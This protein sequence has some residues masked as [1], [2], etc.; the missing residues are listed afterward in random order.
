MMRTLIRLC[1]I[2]LWALG[3]GLAPALAAVHLM[4]IEEVYPGTPDDPDAQYVML[5]MTAAGQR[6]TLN[7]YVRVEDSDGNLLGR[8]GTFNLHVPIGG[9][10][11]SYPTCPAVLIGTQAAENRLGFSFDQIVDGQMNGGAP[12]VPLPLAAGR[13]CFV[14]T[15]GT[16]TYDCVAWEN[17]DCTRSGNCTAPNNQRTGNV[18]GNG[19]DLNFD[20]PTPA[21]ILGLAQDRTQF[22]CPNKQNSV[23]YSGSFPRPVANSGANANS[24]LDGDGLINVL[25]CDPSDSTSLYF[26]TAV[27]G[28]R[29]DSGATTRISWIPQ[30]ALSGSSTVYDIA[31]YS[32]IDLRNSR[33][34]VGA[35]C[36]ASGVATTF[37][38]DLMPDPTV[39][40]GAIY[41]PRAKNNCGAATY[42]DS[43][44]TPDPRDFLD[45]PM[46]P[47]P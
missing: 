28:T 8:F 33:D 35:F 45:S 40:D 44:E 2:L 21:Q 31:K 39:G 38:D 36:L 22:V 46:G 19:C 30:A 6:F 25:D 15:T 23:D 18:S 11:C 37:V 43:T 34:Y 20:G 29:V 17:F 24:D 41:L 27:T 47:C 3:G 12:R 16:V 7:T 9:A 4:V 42:G 32:L 13:A 1:V 26:P 5:R 10:L 14:N